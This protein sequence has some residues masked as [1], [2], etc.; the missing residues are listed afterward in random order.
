[1]SYLQVKSIGSMSLITTDGQSFGNRGIKLVNI[2]TNES[3]FFNSIVGPIGSTLDLKLW[4]TKIIYMLKII[5]YILKYII[6]VQ[7]R[8]NVY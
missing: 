4:L 5:L 6:L 7:I 3:F 8:F 2:K 1:M